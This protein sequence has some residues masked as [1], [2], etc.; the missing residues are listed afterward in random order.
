MKSEEREKFK[1]WWQDFKQSHPG[2]H[3]EALLY[4]AYKA[5]LAVAPTPPEM[6]RLLEENAA[7]KAEVERLRNQRD[8]TAEMYISKAEE[9]DAIQLEVRET[10]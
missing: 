2:Y 9:L 3:Q 4:A 7:L 6:A 8:I 1:K 10:K 5:S